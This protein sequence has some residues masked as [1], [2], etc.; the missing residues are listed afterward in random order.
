M[1]M[2]GFNS[3]DL[4]AWFFESLQYFKIGYILYVS[5]LNGMAKPNIFN[6]E[7]NRHMESV[8]ELVISS[9]FIQDNVME[10]LLPVVRSGIR[11]PSGINFSHLQ[12]IWCRNK[13]KWSS[14]S[15]PLI[16]F[17]SAAEEQLHLLLLK[18]FSTESRAGLCVQNGARKDFL[19]TWHSL[20]SQILFTLLPD[21]C[22]CTAKNVCI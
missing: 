5:V 19:G 11:I 16:R 15:A 3:P 1:S 17:H 12:N 21:Q 14:T 18:L 22:P 4:H 13:N 2:P 7:C 9:Y 8:S 20:L 10:T 6:A